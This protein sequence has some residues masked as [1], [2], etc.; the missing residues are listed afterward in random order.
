MRPFLDQISA[1][2]ETFHA[3]E[4][5]ACM[6]CFEGKQNFVQFFAY[7]G[8]A[9]HMV[10]AVKDLNKTSKLWILDYMVRY[11]GTTSENR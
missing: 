4:I 10:H 3:S 7:E 6:F 9:W 2:N 11:I 8:P 1:H 5:K